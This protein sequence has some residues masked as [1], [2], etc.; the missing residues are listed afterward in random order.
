MIQCRSGIVCAMGVAGCLLKR[1]LSILPLAQI[2]IAMR[3]YYISK[4]IF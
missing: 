4:H 3:K 2:Y 1:L